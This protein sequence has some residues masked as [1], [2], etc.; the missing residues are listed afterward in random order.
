MPTLGNS[1]G[2]DEGGSS[3]GNRGIVF[4]RPGLK[5]LLD[6]FDI[7]NNLSILES[8]YLDTVK[9]IFYGRI[10]DRLREEIH[11]YTLSPSE[12]LDKYAKYSEVNFPVGFATEK[13]YYSPKYPSYFNDTYKQYGA[14]FWQPDIVLSPNS[15]TNLKIPLHLQNQLQIYIEGISESGKLIAKEKTINLE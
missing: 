7:S 8:T 9:E 13:E 5:I 14:I 15:I 11:I 10:P 6:G 12:Y 2:G 4:R 3:S 1:N